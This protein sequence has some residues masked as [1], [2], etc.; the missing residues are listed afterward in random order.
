MVK[1]IRILI[2]TL[3][4]VLL[5]VTVFA[6]SD[7]SVTLDGKPVAFDVP[8]VISE[9]RAFVPMRAVF[10]TFDC[11]VEWFADEQVILATHNTK[12]IM[13][14]IGSTRLVI[15]DVFS[16]ETQVIETDAA[17]FIDN[18]RTL[19]PIRYISEALSCS[20]DW[21]EETRTVSIKK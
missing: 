18:G 20:V 21:N 12:M 11:D 16:S 9:E 15:S 8:P 10:E 2:V 13:L 5:S 4:V 3:L 7:I 1:K 6:G 14:K 17:P 19:V